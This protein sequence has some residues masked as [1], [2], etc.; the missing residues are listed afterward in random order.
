[1]RKAFIIIMTLFISS[2]CD[3]QNIQFRDCF[4]YVVNN[5]INNE[6]LDSIVSLNL[7]QLKSNAQE[8]KL[9]AELQGIKIEEYPSK[10]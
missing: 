1:M 10:R 9:M 8:T 6:S 2:Y 7:F 3:G 4:K 5:N